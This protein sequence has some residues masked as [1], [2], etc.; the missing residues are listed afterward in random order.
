MNGENVRDRE[1]T[2][3]LIR[4]G[5]T[6]PLRK[7]IPPSSRTVSMATAV[8]NQIATSLQSPVSHK[9]LLVD[10]DPPRMSIL[11]TLLDS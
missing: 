2:S 9:H 6:T 8:K 5:G 3:S 1:P 7:D 4:R 11:P 10:E